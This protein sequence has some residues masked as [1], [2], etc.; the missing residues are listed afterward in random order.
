MKSQLI[1]WLH[2]CKL[3]RKLSGKELAE[4]LETTERQVRLLVEE[5]RREGLVED[6][7]LLSCDE[8]YY[9]SDDADEINR[10]LNAYLSHA[11]SRIRT[12]QT[13]K[14]FLSEQQVKGIQTELQF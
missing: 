9:L 11:F 14:R 3:L 8:G 1:S 4:K 5:I 2:A 13:M 7:C 10:F 12:A 6:Y